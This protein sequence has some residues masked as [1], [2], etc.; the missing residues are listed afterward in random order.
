MDPFLEGGALTS[1]RGLSCLP[2]LNSSFGNV[3]LGL[4]RRLE[5]FSCL[6]VVCPIK[7]IFVLVLVEDGSDRVQ[8]LR[9]DV[10]AGMWRRTLF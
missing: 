9:V 6:L 4:P 1:G 3:R 8:F 10:A 7:Q 2:L 5:R